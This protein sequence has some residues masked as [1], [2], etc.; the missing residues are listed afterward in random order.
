[1]TSIEVVAHAK[2]NLFLEVLGKRKDS[3]HKILTI[4]ERI[5]L[6]DEIKILKIPKG[7]RISSDKFITRNPEDNLAYKAAKLILKYKDVKAG[8]KIFIKKRIPIAAG[9]GGG[10]SDAAAVLVGINKLFALRLKEGSLMRL[11]RQLG[12]DVPFFLLGAQFA[13]G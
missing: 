4:F 3:Y 8:V 2:V 1:M 9:L 6:A 7:I 5:S 11:A 12:A 10:S 13:L